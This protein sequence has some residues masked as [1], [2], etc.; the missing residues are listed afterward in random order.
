MGHSNEDKESELIAF[1]GD[2]SDKDSTSLVG[3]DVLRR[4]EWF[5][6]FGIGAMHSGGT[7]CL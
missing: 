5:V 1:V 3:L 7:L 6:R 2:A 4:R